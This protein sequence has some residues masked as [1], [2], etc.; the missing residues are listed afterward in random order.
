[1]ALYKCTNCGH[2]EDMETHNPPAKCPFCKAS[3]EDMDDLWDEM[4]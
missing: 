1:M 3:V 4:E 2:E